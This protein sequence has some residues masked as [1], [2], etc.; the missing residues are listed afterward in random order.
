MA[1]LLDEP[2]EGLDERTYVRVFGELPPLL[3]AFAATTLLVTH[4]RDEALSRGPSGD[5]RQGG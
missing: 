2:L 5:S 1:V 4:N 3:A